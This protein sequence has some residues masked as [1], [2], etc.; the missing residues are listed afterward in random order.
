MTVVVAEHDMSLVERLDS[1]RESGT[2]R[3]P[4]ASGEAEHRNAILSEGERKRCFMPCVSRGS[5]TLTLDF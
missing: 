1:S 2:C 4:L 3:L 5:G